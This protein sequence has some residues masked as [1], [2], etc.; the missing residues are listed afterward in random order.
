M[1]NKNSIKKNIVAYIITIL[2]CIII[3]VGIMKLWDFDFKAPIGYAGDGL[4][5]AMMIKGMVDNGCYLDNKYLAAPVGLHLHY[6]FSLGADSL[7]YLF[8]KFISLF[9]SNW[10]LIKNIFILLTFPL[11]ALSSLFAL[12]NLGLSYASAI[13]SSL[14]FTFLS[15]HFTRAPGHTFLA[16]YYTVPLATLLALWVYSKDPPLLNYQGKIRL[17]LFSSRSI[18]SL[19]ICLLISSSGLYYAFFAC[20]F[21]V[22]AA[23]SD[24]STDK[25]Y[26]RFISAAI[27]VTL[28]SAGVL[29]NIS[30]SLYHRRVHKEDTSALVR[31]PRA[32]EIYGLK[33]SQLI[34]PIG[35][36]R[37]PSLAKFKNQ[38]N[39]TAPLVNENGSS[40]L[41]VI[42]SLGFLLLLLRIII[43][44]RQSSFL[45]PKTE[46]AS[47]L[48]IFNIAAILLATIGGLSSVLS[49]TILPI[50]NAYNRVSIFI[51]FFSFAAFFLFLENFLK[52]YPE[53]KTFF[54]CLLSFILIIGVSDQTAAYYGA[55][56]ASRG[57]Y[58]NDAEFIQKIETILPVNAMV[59]Q[60][61]YIPFPENP[62]V[63]KMLD[64]EQFIPYLHSKKLRWSYGVLKGGREDRW[65]KEITKKPADEFLKDILLRGFSGIYLNRLGYG[66]D[67]ATNIEKKISLLLNAKPQ[68]SP[69]N[70][71]VFFDIRE[72]NKVHPGQKP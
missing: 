39:A 20:F 2:L 34:F 16:S 31:Q 30:P 7:H 38:Y 4:F 62:K 41:G 59:F 71:L 56:P 3:L 35:G 8:I 5:Y 44:N 55:R 58:T 51:A 68:I 49:Y 66:G 28:I 33:I 60:L 23:L 37:L 67:E 43:L 1:F 32:A 25:N 36:H 64:Y 10:A 45:E 53:R 70:T 27:L 24:F 22:V 14:L 26:R 48:A 6:D 47:K 13:V 57:R 21:I 52:K 61:P 65:Q 40:S 29:I 54:Y 46:I 19:V 18:Q 9:S 72:Y 17:T 50:I 15:Y 42:G 12:R 69:D 11:A 63:Y